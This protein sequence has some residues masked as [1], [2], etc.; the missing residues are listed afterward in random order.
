MSVGQP[1]A[2]P[3]SLLLSCCSGGGGAGALKAPVGAHLF[4]CPPKL[5]VGNFLRHRVCVLTHFSL[6]PVL[7][8]VSESESLSS[9]S[10]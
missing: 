8:Y 7:Q 2:P 5:T 4:F 1:A 10:L 6:P 9:S 3:P